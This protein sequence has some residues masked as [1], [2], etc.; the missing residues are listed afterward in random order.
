MPAQRD[1][2]NDIALTHN[3]ARRGP[4]FYIGERPLACA[5]KS[6]FFLKCATCQ[7]EFDEA[8]SD[9]R[10]AALMARLKPRRLV[11]DDNVL[12]L[13]QSDMPF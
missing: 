4:L 12:P 5:G 8:L 11:D 13:R 6:R 2:T 7:A 1:E 9:E 3:C 10:V